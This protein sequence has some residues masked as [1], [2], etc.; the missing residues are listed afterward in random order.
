MPKIIQVS[1]VRDAIYHASGGSRGQGAAS[2]PLLGRL[3]HQVFAELVG[4][5]SAVN[6]YAALA[7]AE[8]GPEGWR[9]ALAEHAYARL[10][11]PRLRRHQ[12]ELQQA[13]AQTLNFWRAVEEMCG[14]LAD[15]LWSLHEHNSSPEGLRRMLRAEYHLD[16][17]LREPDWADEVRLTGR[18]DAVWATATGR[19]CLIELKTGQTAPEADLAQACLYHLML[20]DAGLD[21]WGTLALV[22]FTPTRCEQL[23]GAAELREAQTRLVRLIGRLAGVLPEE[24]ASPPSSSPEASH[25]PAPTGTPPGAPP[26]RPSITPSTPQPAHLELGERLV[27][28]LAEYDAAAKLIAAPVAGPTFLRFFLTPETG[29]K[30]EKILRQDR[31]LQLRLALDAPPRIGIEGGS[32][33]VDVERR[34]RELIPF[35]AIRSQLPPPDLLTGSAAAPVGVGL[36]GRLHFADFGDD[37][38]THLLVAG[39][40]GSGKS[41]WLRV[42]L[43]G[44]MHANTPETLRLLLIDP[45]RNAF[46]TLGGSPF[47]HAPL[48]YP[49]EQPVA[50]VLSSLVE[51]MERRYRLMGETRSDTLAAHVRR[52]GQPI[53]RLFCVCDEYA[54]V[55]AVDNRQR[56]AIEVQ[57][58]RLGAK[59]RAAGIHLIL[60]VQH[61]SS[62]IVRG[63]LNANIPARIGLRVQK[64]LYS[65]MLLNESGAESLLG[66][67]DLLFK[68][69]GELLR[70]QSP[71]LPP[72][73][74]A[75]VFGPAARGEAA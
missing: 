26:A 62:E 67:G 38:V 71:Y 1:E 30:P 48:V 15:K 72:E 19:W 16:L 37:S 3:F 35:S 58:M 52:T 18:A 9:A 59:A 39:T 49:N 66:K 29:V 28:A 64:A 75:A 74:M 36:D 56:R 25:A 50:D 31:A 40:T 17:T 32:L 73:E 47:L 27:A 2:T 4:A 22:S 23:F 63:A 11:G 55:I 5:D 10:V 65:Q 69:G 57:I 12:A 20:A 41:E 7:D 21:E 53:P 13:A 8:P 51:E 34:D 60:A 43:A 42:C 44:L 54:D 6:F 33:V 68:R 24:Q 46:Q 61:P 45:K 70:L 14:W